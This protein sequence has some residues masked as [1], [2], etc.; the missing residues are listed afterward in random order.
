MI[1]SRHRYSSMVVGLIQMVKDGEDDP[2][3][4]QSDGVLTTRREVAS[5]DGEG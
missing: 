1:I 5:A 4:V 2:G 3:P